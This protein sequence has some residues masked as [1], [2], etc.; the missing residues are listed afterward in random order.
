[1]DYG[2]QMEGAEPDQPQ[3]RPSPGR[4]VV[5]AV[6]LAIVAL[7]IAAGGI[8]RPIGT[9]VVDRSS[10]VSRALFGLLVG[11]VVAVAVMSVVR[12]LAWWKGISKPLV[13]SLAVLGVVAVSLVAVSTAA[14]HP[15]VPEPPTTRAA[16][17]PPPETVVP[18]PAPDDIEQQRSSSLPQWVKSVAVLILIA[19]LGLFIVVLSRLMLLRMRRSALPG[20]RPPRMSPGV[21]DLAVDEALER[22]I[23]ALLDDPDQRV[24]IKAAYA[25]LL[26]ALAGAG[27]SKIAS[28]APYEHLSRCLSGMEVEPMAMQQLLDVYSVARF[29]THDVGE[30]ERAMALGALRTA[31]LQLRRRAALAEATAAEAADAA[32]EKAAAAA[33]VGNNP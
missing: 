15:P 19:V 11:V 30:P 8:F 31:Q 27:F 13:G 6:G 29:S 24:A 22:S 5:V 32:A 33:L 26:D 9:N 25:F 4:F 3:L 12:R 1:V 20:Y 7:G 18:R 21:D 14:R 28:E 10:A 16:T 17:A 2:E 23:E